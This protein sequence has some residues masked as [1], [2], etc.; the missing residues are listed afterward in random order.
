MIDFFLVCSLLTFGLSYIIKS[1]LN[2]GLLV[3]AQSLMNCNH[4][5][6]NKR[7]VKYKPCVQK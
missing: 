7:V 6:N 5:W 1:V 2:M 3:L 4:D